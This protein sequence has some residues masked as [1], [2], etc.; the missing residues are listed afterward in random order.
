MKLLTVLGI[1]LA[2]LGSS[3]FAGVSD[4][5]GVSEGIEMSESIGVSE[6]AYMDEAEKEVFSSE[7]RKFKSFGFPDLEYNVNE[8]D[9]YNWSYFIQSLR[10]DGISDTGITG[11]LG[12]I[13]A[14]GVVKEFTID[15]Y[16][17][18]YCYFETGGSYDFYGAQPSLLSDHEGRLSGGDGHGICRWISER[19]DE[20][21]EFALDYDYV[22]FTHWVYD[23]AV[24][25]GQHTC[26]I[27][28]ME[29]QTAFLLYELNGE[30]KDVKE[31]LS[32]HQRQA[33]RRRYF[34]TGIWILKDLGLGDTA[35]MPSPVFLWLR[36]VQV[37]IKD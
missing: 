2:S 24:Q 29:G 9:F 20:L 31:S 28:D 37:F 5:N 11:I 7:V 30:Y 12:N 17:D 25:G 6:A 15:G 16:D 36:R 4:G 13:K 23:G 35:V 26:H 18:R 10:A 27:P 3:G 34:M 32:G 8:D 33:K 19:A 22:T 21:S 1:L 14:A